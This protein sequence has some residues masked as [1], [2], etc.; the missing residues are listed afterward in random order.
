MFVIKKLVIVLVIT[1]LTTP[2]TAHANLKNQT[3]SRPTVAILDT[4]IDTSVT[5]LRGR[6]VQEVCILE[7]PLCPNGTSFMEGPGSASMPSNLINLNGFNHGTQMSSVFVK[8]N[9]NA[10]IVFIKI[11]GNSPTGVRQNAGDATVYNALNW[12][13]NNA[14]K[15]N[16]QA[17]TMA[18][19]TDKGHGAAGTDYCPKTPITVQ[20]VNDLMALQIPVF[21]PSGNREDYSRIDW[22]ACIDASISVGVTN[23][24]G[25]IHSTSNTDRSKL[26][27]FAPGSFRIAGPGN[28]METITGSSASIQVAAGMWLTAKAETGKDYQSLLTA[29]IAY[30]RPTVGRQGKFNNLLSYPFTVQTAAQAAAARA[31]AIKT[32][33]R[34]AAAAKAAQAAEEAARPWK[35]T[36]S[37]TKLS[38]LNGDGIGNGS[39]CSSSSSKGYFVLNYSTNETLNVSINCSIALSVPKTVSGKAL[40]EVRM[41]GGSWANIFSSGVITSCSY[42]WMVDGLHME[43]CADDLEEAVW[44]A[45]FVYKGTSGVLDGKFRIWHYRLPAQAE[46]YDMPTG[47]KTYRFKVLTSKKQK[48]YSPTFQIKYVGCG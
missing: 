43:Q 30:A 13:K 24:I 19:G 29:F 38:I 42:Y 16:I 31:A 26:D 28:V 17:V 6:V 14:S 46:C 27:F 21:F 1:T 11:I 15:Y 25:D 47:T 36:D 45:S 48:L 32:V 4:A 5:G 33:A 3:Q 9:S 39:G 35:I 37:K 20:A 8:N 41:P 44:K 34:A 40:I 22:P 7:L 2:V 23:Q 12:V 10:D 18:H